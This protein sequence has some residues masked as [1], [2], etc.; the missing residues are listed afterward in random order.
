MVALKKILS[1]WQ[2]TLHGVG[3]NALFLENHDIPRIVSKW[4]DP[5]HHWHASATALATLYFLMQGTPYIY[6]GQEIGM[7]NTVFESVDD[8]NDVWAKNQFALRRAAAG[9][10][11]PRRSRPA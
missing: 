10:H 11:A 5:V 1:N 3:W 7:T 8:F 2:D 9:G 4:G 6:Q